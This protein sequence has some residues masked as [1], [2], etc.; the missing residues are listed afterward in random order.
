MKNKVN[1]YIIV[2]NF[3]TRE[4]RFLDKTLLLSTTKCIF[5]HKK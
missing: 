4:K 5:M 1:K 3:K 2:V